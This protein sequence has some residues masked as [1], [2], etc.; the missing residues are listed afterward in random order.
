MSK[1][2]AVARTGAA[3]VDG[4]SGDRGELT[5]ITAIVAYLQKQ[6]FRRI[7]AKELAVFLVFLVC[8]TILLSLQR[9]STMYS[10]GFFAVGSAKGFV[11]PTEFNG[12]DHPAEFWTWFSG[13]T[14][15][16]WNVT[17][18]GDS[19][20]DANYPLLF[21]LLRQFRVNSESCPSTPGYSVLPQQTMAALPQSCYPKYT[22][23]SNAEAAFGPSSQW[24][25]N[26]RLT[27][28]VNSNAA[29]GILQTYDNADAAY[30]ME[31]PFSLSVNDALT[32]VDYLRTNNWIDTATRAVAVEFTTVCPSTQTFVFVSLVVEFTESG[33]VEVYDKYIPFTFENWR[34]EKGAVKAWVCLVLDVIIALTVLYSLFAALRSIRLN[35][36]IH[37]FNFFD[38]VM[39]WRPGIHLSPY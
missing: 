26:S 16:L 34:L 6:A 5:P 11:K 24:L 37:G 9:F 31:I 13:L 32:N 10:D 7:V 27:V 15:R 18:V 23:D 30:A 21:L 17:G 39:V 14:S 4:A 36:I 35:L 25:P 12:I 22:K 1:A 20:R 38:I 28:K 8:L 2:D 19:N 3:G 29:V 33:W